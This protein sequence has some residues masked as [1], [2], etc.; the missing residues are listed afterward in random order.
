MT[1]RE[2]PFLGIINIISTERKQER[3]IFMTK[4]EDLKRLQAALDAQLVSIN[5]RVPRSTWDRFRRAARAD[6]YT[7]QDAIDRA[8][9]EYLARRDNG[10]F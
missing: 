3:K 1:Q 7:V 10:L 4:K 2:E 6:G 9:T 5:S 8:L